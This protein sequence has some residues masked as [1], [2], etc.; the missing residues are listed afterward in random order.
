MRSQIQPE[1]SRLT[2]PQASISDSISRAARRAVAEVAAVGDDVHLR[3]RHR[4][5]AGHAGHAQQRLQ[6][7]R[8]QRPNGRSDCSGAAR[9]AA[10]A[11]PAAPAP[12]AGGRRRNSSASGSIVSTQNTPMPM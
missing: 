7:G 2:M 5:A 8:A 6:P 1:T 9:G 10:G 12:A 11:A 4:H 3:H